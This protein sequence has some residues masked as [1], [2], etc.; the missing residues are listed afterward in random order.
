MVIEFE[1][2]V[3]LGEGLEKDFEML[4]KVWEGN[5]RFICMGSGVV[6]R[7]MMLMRC[8]DRILLVDCLLWVFVYFFCVIVVCYY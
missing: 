4:K 8:C 3:K 2:L 5:S 7:V 6:W 1:K